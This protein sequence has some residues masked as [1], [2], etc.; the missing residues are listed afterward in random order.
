MRSAAGFTKVMTPWGSMAMTP[1]PRL[2]VMVRT[3]SNSVA[4]AKAFDATDANARSRPS[5]FPSHSPPANL[6]VTSTEM[7]PS[8][9]A[10]NE[11]SPIGEPLGTSRAPVAS[12]SVL[13]DASNCSSTPRESMLER[14]DDAAAYSSSIWRRSLYWPNARL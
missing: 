13:A 4:W 7:D 14:M 11:S 3:C 6:P 5:S 1:S 8:T 12:S 9:S 2:L 10:R